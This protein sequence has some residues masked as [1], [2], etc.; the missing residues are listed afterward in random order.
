MR[1]AD[2]RR[3]RIFLILSFTLPAWRILET[4]ISRISFA[5]WGVILILSRYT[6]SPSRL[7]SNSYTPFSIFWF[8]GLF[9]L[10]GYSFSYTWS[11]W[12]SLLFLIF[13]ITLLLLSLFD[14]ANVRRISVRDR[15][16]LMTS[17]M[18][19]TVPNITHLTA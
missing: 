9:T 4:F 15:C 19:I 5:F 14:F 18:D 17:T 8:A 1:R 11:F 2:L 7:S 12:I 13:A 6:M 3:L 10:V 16:Q